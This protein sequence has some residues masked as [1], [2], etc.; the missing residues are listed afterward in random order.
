MNKKT[1]KYKCELSSD[2]FK[3]L[4]FINHSEDFKS[5]EHK[6]ENYIEKVY[7]FI[8]SLDDDY[9]NLIIKK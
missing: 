7:D 8:E 1:S 6:N 2:K 3:D 4:K 9:K 5:V